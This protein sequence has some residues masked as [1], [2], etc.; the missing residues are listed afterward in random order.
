MKLKGVSAFE[1]HVEKLLFLLALGFSAYIVYFH[2]MGAPY[3]VKVA[4][5]L[6]SPGEVEDVVLEVAKR[7]EEKIKPD[8]ANPL[9]PMKVAPYTEYFVRRLEEPVVVSEQLPGF[10]K[11]PGLAIKVKPPEVNNN[12]INIPTPPAPVGLLAKAGHGVLDRNGDPGVD[13][14]LVQLVGGRQ[15]RDFRYVSVSA[16]FPM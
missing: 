2:G 12:G 7:L 9:P 6:K 4:G 14:Q 11:A 3:S 1:L 10:L 15:P 16:E 13:Q 8:S 5:Q